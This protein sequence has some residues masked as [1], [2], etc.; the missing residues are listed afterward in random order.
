MTFKRICAYLI[1]S[2]LMQCFAE[3]CIASDFANGLGV[4]EQIESAIGARLKSGDHGVRPLTDF[5]SNSIG[6]QLI[7]TRTG[8]VLPGGIPACNY[9]LVV[10]NNWPNQNNG[11]LQDLE[12]LQLQGA[13]VGPGILSVGPVYNFP[14]VAV[15]QSAP[16][17]SYFYWYF[18]V[19]G[20]ADRINMSYIWVDHTTGVA[21]TPVLIS[22]V[23]YPYPTFFFTWPLVAP[24][25]QV[26]I[27]ALRVAPQAQPSQLG[28]D[29]ESGQL[30]AFCSAAFDISTGNCTG[31]VIPA[32]DVSYTLISGGN[33]EQSTTAVPMMPLWAL[34]TSGVLLI[35]M[36][37]WGYRRGR[38]GIIAAR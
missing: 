21:L 29:F 35:G 7:A 2:L 33:E 10:A 23:A 14:V 31:T 30:T 1:A 38:V 5:H 24:N 3:T 36:A 19:V 9:L 17:A 4:Q 37:A 20:C 18:G 27:P 25:L 34:L 12:V 6:T 32:G 11:T 16:I 28:I 15:P 8:G 22:R 26:L 13:L